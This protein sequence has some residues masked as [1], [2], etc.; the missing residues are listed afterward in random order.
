[1]ALSAGP[2][3]PPLNAEEADNYEEIEK[4]FAV[5]GTLIRMRLA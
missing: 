5:K 2:G 1:M 3:V 4:Q